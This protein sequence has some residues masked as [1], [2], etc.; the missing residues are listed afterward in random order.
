MRAQ[1][2]ELA[3]ERDALRAQLAGDLPTATRWLQRK[4]WRQAAALDVLNRRV[5]TQRFV[6]RT[7]DELGRSLTAEEYRAARA[8]IAN[9]DLRDRIDDPD[10]P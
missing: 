5:V 7:L 10:A 1:L 6:L 2:V 4:V 8:G 9:T 3:A